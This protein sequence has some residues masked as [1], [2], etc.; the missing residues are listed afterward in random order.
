MHISAAVRLVAMWRSCGSTA[1]QY[2]HVAAGAHLVPRHRRRH[3]FDLRPRRYGVIR[4][5]QERHR[6]V[7]EQER[8]R[9]A[10]A[11]QANPFDV[12]SQRFIEDQIRQENVESL[13]QEAIEHMPESFGTVVMLYVA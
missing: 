12:D 8:I 9:R 7:A 1:V 6:R 10:A 11:L 5:E 3:C 2:S 13:R 4:E